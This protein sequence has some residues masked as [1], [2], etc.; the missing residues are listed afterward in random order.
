MRRYLSFALGAF[1][2]VVCS[3]EPAPT[4]LA[5]FLLELPPASASLASRVDAAV[6]AKVCPI[7]DK[8]QPSPTGDAHDYVS[9]ARYWWPDPAKPGG[10]PFIRRDGHSNAAQV[11]LGDEPCLNHFADTV[12]S[13][14]FGWTVLHR[15]DCARRAG[16]WLRAWFITPAT[17]MKP[18]LDYAQI[19]LGHDQNLGSASGVLDAR[20]LAFVTDALR[21]LHD[22][23]A[24]TADEEAAV[25]TWFSDYAH[26]LA[27]GKNAVGEHAAPNNHGSWYLVQTVAIAR[28]LGRDAEA[29][30]LCEE[31]RGRIAGQIKPDGTQPAELARADGLGY[32][33]FNLEAQ[34]QLAHL[35]EALGVDLW[36]DASPEGASLKQAFAYLLP[37]NGGQKKW[38]GSQYRRITPNFLDSLMPAARRAWPDLFAGGQ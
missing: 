26:W 22:S 21:L 14:A 37:Y 3:A 8:P 19:R 13:L 2:A 31:D 7:V 10:L 32:S 15:A 5:P 30:R 20:S 36:H 18:A 12:E 28:Y 11:K 34:F 27:T 17:R 9:Y 1:A 23:P 6:A 38:P 4:P 29:R 25:R 16:E 35:A 24:L 33:V